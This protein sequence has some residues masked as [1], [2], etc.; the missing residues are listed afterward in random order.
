VFVTM[1]GVGGIVGVRVLPSGVGEGDGRHEV[2][3]PI[4]VGKNVGSGVG[5]QSHPHS[6]RPNSNPASFVAMPDNAASKYEVL[7]PPSKAKTISD[8]DSV[9]RFT[10]SSVLSPG[11]FKSAAQGATAGKE[12]LV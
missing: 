12:Q 8:I 10:G 1:K 6:S 3:G 5:S 9:S 4:V 2:S 7:I 11:P